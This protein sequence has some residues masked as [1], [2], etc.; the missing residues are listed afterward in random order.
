MKR[1]LEEDLIKWKNDNSRK[2]LLITGARQVGKTYLIK[3]IFGPQN[4]QKMIY[5]DFREDR[6]IRKFVK[7]HPNA[8]EIINYLNLVYDTTIDKDTLLFFDEIQEAV[9]ILTAAKYFCQNYPEIPVI[10][11][12]SLVRVKLKQLEHDNDEKIVFDPEIDKENQDGNNN[13]FYP[14]GKIDQ[15]DMYVMTF[16]EFLLNYKPSLYNAIKDSVEKGVTLQKEIHDLAMEAFYLYLQIGGLPESV[17]NYLETKSVQKCQST[18]KRIYSDYLAD[19]G[20]YQISTTAIVRSRM[21]FENIFEQLNKENKNFKISE[22]EKGKRFRDYLTPFD[23]LELS[24]LIYKSNLVKER[25]SLPLSSDNGSLF[26]VYLPDCGLFTYESKI[27]LSSFLSSLKVNTLS[28]I[29][30][31]N[32]VAEELT[33]RNIP[34][35]YWKGKTSSEFEFLIT[36]GDEIVPV[37]VKKS[38]GNLGS[39]EVYKSMNH[40]SYSLKIS[41]NNY[42]YDENT[43]IETIPLYAVPFY[44]DKLKKNGEIQ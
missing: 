35:L 27:N 26:R 33:A 42:G 17:S 5:V 6:D 15:L 8:K 39:L 20:L 29:F 28:G 30:M 18:I 9:Q 31:E 14:V 40:C 22:I 23:W 34:L 25:V 21:I 10:M 37:D 36:I 38:R 32:Y 41:A 4:F 13:F 2:P 16:D 12:G 11:A 43:G 19:M 44:L 7:N 1:K 24:R 3:E